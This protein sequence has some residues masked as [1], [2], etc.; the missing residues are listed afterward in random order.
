MSEEYDD[1]IHQRLITDLQRPGGG[2]TTGFVTLL[3]GMTA[4][5]LPIL[6]Y[7]PAPRWTSLVAAFACLMLHIM[8]GAHGYY[9]R[10]I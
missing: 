8:W 6:G 5:V 2:W 1:R 7:W 3:A 10:R 9:P 4:A